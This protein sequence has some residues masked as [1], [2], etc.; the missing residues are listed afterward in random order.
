MIELN[1][2]M[3]DELDITYW[4]LNNSQTKQKSNTYTIS[5]EEKELLRKILLVKGITLNK[6]NV[7]IY[8]E[9]VVVVKSKAHQ[10]VFDDVTKQDTDQLIH[11]SKLSEML[12]SVDQKK[13][14]WHKLKNL[15]I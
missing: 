6:D 11:L 1:Q 5:R 10:L 14:T 8:D 12:K 13:Q 7:E 4:Q 3:C 9:G 2:Q 15:S